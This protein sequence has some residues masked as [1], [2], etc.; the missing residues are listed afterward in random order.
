MFT[1]RLFPTPN[2]G[3]VAPLSQNDYLLKV[4]EREIPRISITPGDERVFTLEGDP[5]GK[6]PAV[7][8]T[9]SGLP[10]VIDVLADGKANRESL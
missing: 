8:C 9:V 5:S 7:G 10:H 3:F 4:Q 1:P 2:F 6:L